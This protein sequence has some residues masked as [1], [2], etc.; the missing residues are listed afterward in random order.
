L[1]GAVV[2]WAENLYG[3]GAN[4]L[5][6]I[7][8]NGVEK[9]GMFGWSWSQIGWNFWLELESNGLEYMDIFGWSWSP[10]G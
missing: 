7:D 2:K 6:H 9:A 10:L 5:E 8:R 4:G 1:V 3:A